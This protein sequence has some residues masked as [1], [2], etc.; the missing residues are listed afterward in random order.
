MGDV[1]LEQRTDT[2]NVEGEL[3]KFNWGA[4]LLNW[5]WAFGHGLW[6]WGIL[7]LIPLVGTIVMFV[8]GFKGNRWAWEKGDYTGAEDLRRRER[9][10]AWAALWVYLGIFVLAFL[11]GLLAGSS[12]S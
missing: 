1:A 8:L 2:A 9:K 6:L 5:I 11:I 10:W 4:F 12:E 3:R 7:G